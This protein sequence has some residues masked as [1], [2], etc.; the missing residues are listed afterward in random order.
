M[1]AATI[2]ASSREPQRGHI[3]MGGDDAALGAGLT[4]YYTANGNSDK[5]NLNQASARVPFDCVMS[6]LRCNTSGAA[7]AGESLTFTLMV[8][9]A[10]SALTCQIAG[11]AATEAE[12]LVNEVNVAEDDLICMRV[13]STGAAN[14]VHPTWCFKCVPAG[15]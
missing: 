10:A 6:E 7:G 4:R 14:A 3:F 9:G 11:A 13:V 5:A 8:E 1:T 15:N 2:G 12:D